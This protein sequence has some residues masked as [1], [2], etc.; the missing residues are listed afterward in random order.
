MTTEDL[1]NQ[2]QPAAR[3]RIAVWCVIRV[4]DYRLTALRPVDPDE[5]EGEQEWS[6]LCGTS[7]MD[8]DRETMFQLGREYGG[9]LMNTEGLPGVRGMTEF[10]D[11]AKERLEAAKASQG[12]PGAA[13][14]SKFATDN[15]NRA[16][17]RAARKAAA[18]V[19]EDDQAPY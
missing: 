12:A 1:A 3:K 19:S 7:R 17:A 10:R 14:Q 4:Q 5:P 8:T 9:L 16:K 11:A 15:A 6:D 2:S 18:G 13:A